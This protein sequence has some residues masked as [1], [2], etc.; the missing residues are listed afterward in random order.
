MIPH[1][2]LG[3]KIT[4]NSADQVIGVTDSSISLVLPDGTAPVI[5][6]QFENPA[7]PVPNPAD[8]DL[9]LVDITVPGVI[10]EPELLDG[11]L[12][13]IDSYIGQVTHGG[14]TS[15]VMTFTHAP[16]GVAATD[17]VF[18]L[19]G[20][21][22]AD[23]PSLADPVAAWNA[24]ETTITNATLVTSGPFA[25]GATIPL[26]GNDAFVSGT[27]TQIESYTPTDDDITTGA[28]ND[29]VDIGGGGFD[30]VRTLGGND[31]VLVDGDRG[32]TEVSVDLGVGNDILDL[33]D[34]NNNYVE[35]RHDDG[36]STGIT[37]TLNGITDIGRVDKGAAGMTVM[38]QPNLAMKSGGMGIYGTRFDDVFNITGVDGGFVQVRGQGGNDRITVDTSNG[39]VRLDY[40]GAPS[41]I[42]ADL[43]AGTVQDGHGGTDTI[44]GRATELRATMQNDQITGS[45]SDENFILMAG[46][47]TLDGGAGEDTARYDR[48]QVGAVTVDL[49]AGTATG[50][51]RG[52]NFTHTL[53]NIENL[54]GSR[55]D[56]DRL[57][58]DAGGNR[59]QGRGGND[60]I[61][62]RGGDDILIGEEGDDRIDGGTGFDRAE[63][64]G[65]NRADATITQTTTG[66]IQV[67]TSLGLDTL[68]N[69]E[70]LGFADE[71]V[72]VNDLFPEPGVV[73]GGGG[74]DTLTGGDDGE[75]LTSGG[76]G[77]V[78][79]GGGGDDTIDGGGGNDTLRGGEGNDSIDGGEGS[80][81]LNG[82]D[83]ADSLNGGSS[84][85][86]LRDVIFGGSGDDLID[87]GA[88]NDQ[89]FGMS[90]NDT[91]AGGFGV[92]ELQG[93]TGDDVITG[94]AFS[95]LVF[96]G[97]G[98]DFV[99]GGFGHD[100][101]NGGTGADKFFH[102]GIADH[103]SDWV[104]DYAHTEG[105]VL[106]F[107]NSA[108]T[109]DDFQVNFA[110]TANAEGERA[111][112]D[113]VR[114]AFVIYKPSGQI[115]WALV[116]G[117]GQSSINLQIGS[118][119]FDL[120]A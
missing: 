61:E 83:G 21:P 79:D 59:I 16:V 65:I 4:R 48:N 28:G 115:M 78:V 35:L 58:G 118:D 90:G 54:R 30:T 89:I 17:W 49:A 5:T 87:G 98:N 25:P 108:A 13:V 120:L 71:S 6:Y 103:G 12:N 20:A 42:V 14:V 74:D 95:D 29:V 97:D 77:D 39:G 33:A 47:D 73:V 113:A 44:I 72:L 119:T 55:D 32:Y 116:D 85:G 31:F 9:P 34:A 86:D 92:D 107:G 100:R 45:A 40:R 69:V 51:W 60:T 106:F 27:G 91:I 93:Q 82:G 63:F 53:D 22:V 26:S 3:Y 37:A 57:S 96:G 50:V 88:G 84:D 52:Q 38:L 15:Y 62:G 66:E 81:T 67:A 11:D 101:I 76:G 112:D 43:A 23:F 19:G 111:G 64:W 1:T 109:A 75:E 68:S 18:L 110:H 80:D 46:N 102:I 41:G 36:L 8:E 104:Q 114:E 70:E 10:G 117:E 56:N 94:S 24:F 7:N 99:N 105:D 2:F